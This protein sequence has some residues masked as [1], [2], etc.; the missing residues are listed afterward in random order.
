M[1]HAKPDKK[2]LETY[3][4]KRNF[5]ATREPRGSTARG[6]SKDLRLVIQKH[7]ASHLHFDLRLELDGVMK[8]WAVPKGP[9]N[10][11]AVKRLAMEVEDHP[12]EY[13]KFEGTIPKGEYGGGTVMLWDRGTYEPIEGDIDDLRA[14]FSKGSIKFVAHGERMKGEWALVRMHRGD[15]R[16]W[17]LI[18]HR[19]KFARAGGKLATSATRSVTTGRTM[20]EIAAEGASDPDDDMRA[21][22]DE[23]DDVEGIAPMLAHVGHDVPEGKEWAFEPKYDGIRII[24]Y[25][26]GSAVKLLTRN[27]IDKA[28]QFPEIV[29]ALSALSRKKKSPLVLDGEIVARS[30]KALARFQTLQ[31]RIH[32]RDSSVIAR[33]ARDVPAAL[34]VFDLLLDRTKSYV[35]EAYSTRRRALRSLMSGTRT[36]ALQLG[37]SKVGDGVK[38]LA[39]ARRGGWEG[40]M[41]K[42]VDA[43]YESG[44]RSRSW[45]KL[46]LEARQEF[47]VGGWTEPRGSREHM[48]ALLLGYWRGGKF[49][50]AGHTGGGFTR[51][52]LK[53]MSARLAPL[54]I[55]KSPFEKL[56]RTNAKPHW[57]KP[58]VVVEVKFNEWTEDGSLRQPILLGVRDDKAARTV[59][60]EAE[61]VRRKGRSIR[62]SARAPEKPPRGATK[63]DDVVAQLRT[64]EDD[65]GEGTLT[66]PDGGALDVTNLGKKYFPK[67][68]Y[69]KG[70]VMRY[71]ASVG[72]TILPL[73]EDRPL[74]LK[75]YPDGIDA[76]PFFQ[77]NAPRDVPKG[78]RTAS[79]GSDEGKSTRVVG[80]D[81]LTLLYTVQLGAIDVHPWLSRVKSLKYADYAVLDLDPTP[82]APFSRVVTI[83]TY[84]LAVL[85]D[86]HYHAAIKTSGSRGLH[87][88]ISL[89]PRTTYPKAQEFARIIATT[90]AED[91][92]KEATVERSIAKRPRGTVY[93]DFLQNAEGKS[94]AAAFSVR[95]RDGAPVSMPIAEKEL[96]S[97]L[98]IEDFTIANAAAQAA[99]RGKIWENGL[100]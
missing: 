92:P 8:S 42:H 77:Q 15:G 73:I 96:V 49:V 36:P 79:I 60:R 3:R 54:E 43:P 50:Y 67:Q 84:V 1:V 31:A 41:A 74:V 37:K 2:P 97:G 86:G 88:F 81:L 48:G 66:F 47:V 57:T 91:Y 4:K 65:S 75:R 16:Q 30:A 62:P 83:A 14:A 19:D 32:E 80:G 27:G 52:S 22:R 6:S 93:V 71:Y 87:I 90:V 69:T 89:P 35:H 46:K 20:R 55:A 17:L 61:S 26:A 44:S 94:V 10:D 13:N 58:K 25:A 12:T 64:I 9:S 33:R 78:V 11:P 76:P 82:A 68:K 85:K 95:A 59:T 72:D 51:Q 63:K 7:D 98:H 40:I 29:R 45:L 99:K 24:A 100:R 70:D 56:P 39:E 5:R 53:E 23:R 28:A 18:K 38:L 34:I 21:E